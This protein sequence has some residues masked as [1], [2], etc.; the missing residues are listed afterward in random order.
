M[1]SAHSRQENTGSLRWCQ[2]WDGNHL[3]PPMAVLVPSFW[4]F[5]Q[6]S[7]DFYGAENADF[8]CV[9][10][11]YSFLSCVGLNH[12]NVFINGLMDLAVA[13]AL[14]EPLWLHRVGS[15]LDLGRFPPLCSWCAGCHAVLD[16]ADLVVLQQEPLLG[17][18]CATEQT[19][20]LWACVFFFNNFLLVQILCL[21]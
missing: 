17:P 3:V 11:S 12:A 16:I 1:W 20:F 13:F 6:N 7:P 4:H 15:V 5:G 8:H 18:V 9:K 2:L 21:S 19:C 14:P 10:I